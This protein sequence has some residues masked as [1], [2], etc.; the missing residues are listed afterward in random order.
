MATGA[1]RDMEV[2][3]EDVHGGVDDLIHCPFV[4]TKQH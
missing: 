4:N 3:V 1:N 2:P